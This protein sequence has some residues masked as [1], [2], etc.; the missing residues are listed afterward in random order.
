MGI[1][2]SKSREKSPD[3]TSK[4]EVGESKEN[5]DSAKDEKLESDYLENNTKYCVDRQHVCSR[6]EDIEERNC[7]GG[8]NTAERIETEIVIKPELDVHYANVSNQ[9]KLVNIP[10]DGPEIVLDEDTGNVTTGQVSEI[11]FDDE[12]NSAVEDE[13]E[14]I[15][16]VETGSAAEQRSEIIVDENSDVAAEQEAELIL[17]EDTESVVEQEPEIIFNESVDCDIVLVEDTD[18]E[19]IVDEDVHSA[20]GEGEGDNTDDVIEQQHKLRMGEGSSNADDGQSEITLERDNISKI[21]LDENVMDE[22]EDT[23]TVVKPL[24]LRVDEQGTLSVVESEIEHTDTDKITTEYLP[25][26]EET[27][28]DS[29]L[30]RSNTYID[31]SMD[32]TVTLDSVTVNQSGEVTGYNYNLPAIN[33]DSTEYYTTLDGPFVYENGTSLSAQP[34]PVE[35]SS[36]KR[37]G[38]VSSSGYYDTSVAYE[39]SEG[40]EG[41]KKKK[42]KHKHKHKHKNRDS[43]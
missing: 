27:D 18:S 8:T 1:F 29:E 3:G 25:L 31:P 43:Y 21:I 32:C 16:D 36:R 40:R 34:A 41:S 30:R 14:I 13:E 19:I 9:Q 12:T 10:D 7:V 26:F 17:C 33:N 39:E 35:T 42:K 28:S 5:T 20:V 4:D 15:F 37:K 2:Y 38:D 6:L 11:I 23:N 22:S 24:T